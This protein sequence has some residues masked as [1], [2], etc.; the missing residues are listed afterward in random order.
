MQQPSYQLFSLPNQK[1]T[2]PESIKRQLPNTNFSAKSDNS[3]K[4]VLV[5]RV[6]RAA[7]EVCHLKK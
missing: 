6:M 1:L 4:V 7:H 3:P 2:L 5:E